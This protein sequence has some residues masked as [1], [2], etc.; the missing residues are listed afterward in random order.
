MGGINRLVKPK[1]LQQNGKHRHKL[2]AGVRCGDLDNV[3]GKTEFLPLELEVDCDHNKGAVVQQCL[4][5]CCEV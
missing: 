5:V 1:I 2:L 4:R 3:E